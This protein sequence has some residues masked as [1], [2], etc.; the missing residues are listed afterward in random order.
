MKRANHNHWMLVG[1]VAAGLVTSWAV[2]PARAIPPDP[3]NAALLYYQAFLTVADLDKEARDNIADVARG[4]VAPNEKTREYV[5]KCRG[6]IDFADAAKDLQVCNWGFRYS[7]GFDALMPYLAQMRFLTYV[8]LADGRIRAADGD[9]KGALERCLQMGTFSRHVGDDTLIAYLVGVAVQRLSYQCMNDI[10]GTAGKD[11]ELLRWLKSELVTAGGKQLSPATSLRIEME[12]SLNLMQ[13][14]KLDKLASMMAGA[15]QKD[16]DMVKFLAS[17][18]EPALE[19]ARQLYSGYLTSALAVLGG[20]KPYEQAHRELTAPISGLDASDPASAIVRFI[21]PA[22]ASTLSAK[23]N[24]EACANATKTAVDICLQRAET[25]RLPEVLPEGLPK[26]PFS[27]QDF[28]YERT[29]NGFVLRC[30]G[31]DLTKDKTYEWAFTVK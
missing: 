7:Q 30:R 22:L 28:Q 23:T 1:I 14:D 24:I 11:A 15:E 16:K 13:M 10:I 9:Y 12:I 17:A 19:R 21:T 27:G 20:T 25:G 4:T 26:D 3:D 31:K 29:A 2:S 8:L 5:N 18:D 6:A